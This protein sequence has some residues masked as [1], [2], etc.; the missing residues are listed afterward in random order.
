MDALYFI[1][2]DSNKKSL[3]LN[4]KTPEGK[5]I[6]EKLIRE[7]DV[8]VENLTAGAIDRMG[9][10]SEHIQELN[11]RL[12]FDSI[13][14]FGEGSPIADLKVYDNVAQCAGGAASTTG[15]RDRP[16]T[17]GGAALATAIPACIWRSAC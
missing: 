16:P 4:T 1:T 15:F 13:K 11:P 2:L 17:V 7:A 10:A 6:V 14:S 5:A 9:F 12:I 3:T 8:L